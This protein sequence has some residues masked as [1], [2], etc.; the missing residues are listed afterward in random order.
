M[1]SLLSLSNSLGGTM[2][3][4]KTQEK[5]LIPAADIA[6][7]VENA[8][9]QKAPKNAIIIETKPLV[10]RDYIDPIDEEYKMMRKNHL[11]TIENRESAEGIASLHAFFLSAGDMPEL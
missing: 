8:V 1:P 7:V 10:T 4:E 6:L 11:G 2:M 9:K 5:T 3:T